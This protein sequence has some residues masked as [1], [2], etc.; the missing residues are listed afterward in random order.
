MT[1]IIE[2]A[3][4]YVSSGSPMQVQFGESCTV[5]SVGN[6][7]ET[8]DMTTGVGR[9]SRSGHTLSVCIAHRSATPHEVA[10]VE[11][12][13]KRRLIHMGLRLVDSPALLTGN[14]L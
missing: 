13:V 6:Y 3:P 12:H 5:E 1:T 2:P 7:A 8:L 11:D 14:A 10:S 9:V 4:V